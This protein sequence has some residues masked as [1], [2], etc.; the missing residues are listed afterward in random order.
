M[1]RLPII[2]KKH[3]EIKT[4]YVKGGKLTLSPFN[5]GMESLL[6]QVKDGEKEEQQ[7]AVKQV[8]QECLITEG[9]DVGKLP[10]F[11]IGEIFLR[12][13]QH[14]IGEIIE[15]EYQ[16]T[17]VVEEKPCNTK[18][19][20]TI[21]LTEFK[22]TENPVHTNTIMVSDPIGIVFRYPDMDMAELVDGKDEAELIIECIES[23]FD[24]DNVYP[25]E[26]HTKEELREFWRKMTLLQKKDVYDRFFTSMPSFNMTKNLKCTK[27]GHEHE[28]KFE[29]IEDVFPS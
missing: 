2:P 6:L 15:Q 21:D 29:K 26:D 3:F 7:S 9:V 5:V 20:L 12:L 13:R 8:I 24:A 18:L 17:N 25:A 14:S 4:K 19:K 1:S 22:L 11:L 23:I 27:C 28:I 16:C 10:T